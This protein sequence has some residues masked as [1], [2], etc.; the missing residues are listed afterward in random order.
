[1]LWWGTAAIVILLLLAAAFIWL[2]GVKSQQPKRL[3]N[4]GQPGAGSSFERRDFA[5]E[6][7][8]SRLEG[9]LLLPAPD[10]E[11]DAAKPPLVI[12]AHGW[13]SNRARVLRYTERLIRQG[14]A[15]MMYDA[16]SHG[17]SESIKAPSA[18]MFRDDIIAAVAY[19][20][21]LEDIDSTRIA[22]LGHSMGGF[23][24]LLALAQGLKVNAIVTD[25]MPVQ[26]ETMLRAEL[27]RK[28][29]P[30]FPL[31]QCI[32][33][34]WFYRSGITR[35][36]LRA[37]DIPAILKCY[38]SS[39]DPSKQAVLMVHSLRDSFIPAQELQELEKELQAG[40]V[41]SLYVL[42]E[43]HSA[44]E[45]D[46]AFWEH[47]LPFLREHLQAEEDFR[48]RTARKAGGD[49]SASFPQSGI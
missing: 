2:I 7:G 25:S 18:F 10:R 38:A 17:D 29:L 37:A 35:E 46:P 3:P 33:R 1:M 42:S 34:I 48:A 23:G 44:S 27:K 49:D 12:I 20:R 43:G 14:Y 11:G 9:W 40:T 36:Q 32:P 41:Q 31:M 45:Q 15:V 4:D 13:G 22:L 28:K 26:F 16:R 8:G 24:A 21:K 30:L 6:S 47:V 39:S 5:F 19:S